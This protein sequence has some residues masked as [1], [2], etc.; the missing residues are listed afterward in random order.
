MKL[1][2]LGDDAS[3]YEYLLS[4]AE[5]FWHG[6]FIEQAK[7]T[8]QS[9]PPDLLNPQQLTRRQIM[10]AAIALTE[11]NPRAALDTA[12]GFGLENESLEA[13]HTILS[14]RS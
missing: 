10:E 2:A 11:H 7:Q 3:H 8:L 14:I 9:L 12:I 13:S 4:A 6:N 1:A 5:S